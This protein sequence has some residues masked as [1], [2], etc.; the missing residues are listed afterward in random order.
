[1]AVV[2]VHAWGW[3]P[4]SLVTWIAGGNVVVADDATV[5]EEACDVAIA[6][7]AT[8]DAGWNSVHVAW[9]A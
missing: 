2:E 9:D 4:R 3:S 5:V 1:M 8:A 7:A 6:V